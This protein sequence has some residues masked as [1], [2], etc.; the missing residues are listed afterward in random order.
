MDNVATLVLGIGIGLVLG[1]IFLP[2]PKFVRDFFVRIGWAN[3]R[4]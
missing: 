3:P 4:V 2:E 1:W